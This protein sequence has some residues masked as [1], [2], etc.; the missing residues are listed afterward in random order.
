MFWNSLVNLAIMAGGV[1]QFLG[2]AGGL[3]FFVLSI[4]YL[5]SDHGD[6]NLFWFFDIDKWEEDDE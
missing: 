1:L 3:L 6:G 2:L 5:Y 4:A